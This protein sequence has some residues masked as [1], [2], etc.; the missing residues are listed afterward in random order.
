MG[1]TPGLTASHG[2]SWVSESVFIVDHFSPHLPGNFVGRA[3]MVCSQV[4]DAPAKEK[5]LREILVRIPYVARRGFR[6]VC[7]F[8][9]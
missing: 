3:G 4:M 7:F 5:N 8:L 1:S 2:R 9:F 6:E